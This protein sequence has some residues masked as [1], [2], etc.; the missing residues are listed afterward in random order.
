[1][2][3]PLLRPRTRASCSQRFAA[4]RAVLSP[5]PAA[6]ALRLPHTRRRVLACRSSSTSSSEQPQQPE[7]QPHRPREQQ[8]PS[9]R[10]RLS[11][12]V[13]GALPGA[14]LLAASLLLPMRPAHAAGSGSPPGGTQLPAAHTTSAAAEASASYSAAGAAAQQPAW[15]QQQQEVQQQGVQQ[16]QGWRDTGILLAAKNRD[17]I[18]LM[19]PEELT[20]TGN[21]AVNKLLEAQGLSPKEM[22]AVK[23]KQLPSK[24]GQK[25]DPSVSL[26]PDPASIPSASEFKKAN[27]FGLVTMWRPEHLRDMTYTQFWNLVRERKVEQVK[28][29]N[30]RRSIIVT[31]KPTA[32]GGA[33]TE[34]VGLPFDPQ[35]LDH[36][37]MHGVYIEADTP[38]PVM[39]L[40][41]ALARLIFP[42]AFSFLL[43]KFAFRLGSKKQRDRIFGGANLELVKPEDA[44]YSFKDI[45]GID[46]V[47]EEITEIV[48]FLRDPNRFL[49]LGAR[50]PAGVLMVGA[51]GTG[52]TLLAK[53]VAGESGVPFFSIAGTEFMEMFV[54]VGA[55]RVRDIFKQARDNAPCILFIDEFDGVGQSRSYGGGGGDENVH[56][57]NQLLTEMDGFEDNTGIVVM[58]ATNRPTALDAALTRPGRFDRIVHMPLPNVDGRV[59]I[60][61]VHARGKKMDPDLD[62]QKIARATAGFTGAELMNLMNQSAILAVRQQQT[63]I[64]E[65][66]VFEALENIQKDKM[67]GRGGAGGNGEADVVPPHQRR[68]IAVYEAARALIGYITPEFDEVQRVSVCPA[69]SNNGFTYFLPREETLE[70]R[71]VTKG[72]MESKMVVALAG[73]S[74]ERLVLGDANIST[75]GASQLQTANLIAREMIF[76]CGFSSRLGPVSMMDEEESYL[77]D[78]GHAIADISTEIA[79]IAF[80]E[81]EELVEAAEAKAYYGLARNYEA[82]IALTEALIQRQSLTGEELR[83]VLEEHHVHRYANDSVEGYGWAP[84]GGL[85][86]PGKAESLQEVSQQVADYL[87]NQ[88]AASGGEGGAAPRWWAP[89]SP[90]SVRTDIADLLQEGASL[91]RSGLAPSGNASGGNGGGDSGG[92]NGTA[93]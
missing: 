44:Q 7:Q 39:P 92:G 43:I 45:A 35:L 30:D 15:A 67:G 76:R 28:Y 47:K 40:L 60:L 54:G 14:A 21:A 20:Q 77:G 91:G 52:K 2:Q 71:V 37:V 58:A 89:N 80:Q 93:K 17:K 38:N 27:N 84:D 83:A 87:A 3:T 1:M 13:A 62:Y 33:R 23:K 61:K 25:V 32:P 78:N 53:A 36:M 50:S 73:R 49:S 4:A 34:K 82:L 51:P 41:H 68:S 26:V 86:W 69:G 8:P 16:Q 11:S 66:Q 55:S 29:T 12:W 70:S 75:V 59:G 81:V 42:I 79:V 57:I 63:R 88:K 46:Q 90:Y 18:T 64:S 19:T 48:Q 74:A 9:Q 85:H 6:C 56:T 22:R 65:A 72:Y 10:L 24:G 5:P 31:T